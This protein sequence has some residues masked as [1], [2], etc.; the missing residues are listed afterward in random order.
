LRYGE[1]PQKNFT[2]PKPEWV[3]LKYS[4]NLIL[5]NKDAGKV[6]ISF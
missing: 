2:I 1:V 5:E 4:I 6:L 3:N